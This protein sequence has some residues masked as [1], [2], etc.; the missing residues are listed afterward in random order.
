MINEKQIHFQQLRE[1]ISE[2]TND[3]VVWCG[4]GLSVEVG[5]PGWSELK[6]NILE[7]SEYELEIDES[8]L[9]KLDSIKKQPDFWISFSMLKD[10]LGTSKYQALIKKY[11]DVHIKAPRIYEKIWTLNPKGVITVNIDRFAG[12]SFSNV[13]PGKRVNEFEGFSIKDNYRLLRTPDNFIVNIHGNIDK[14]NT[15]VFTKEELSALQ[16]TDG[17][18]EFLTTIFSSN[19]VLFIGISADDVAVGGL[20]NNLVNE[21]HIDLGN[22]YWI[23]DRNDNEIKKWADLSH[24]NIIKHSAGKYE[25]VVEY[26]DNILEFI[27]KDMDAMPVIMD[28]IYPT[29]IIDH[30]ELISKPANQIRYLLNSHAN[31][32]LGCNNNKPD[33]EKYFHFLD[34]FDQEI[35]NAWYVGLKKPHNEIF[36]YQLI[37]NIGSGGFGTV[38]E[39]EKDGEKYAIKILHQDIRYQE[40]K[41][42]SFRRGVRS[43]KILAG[44]DMEGIVKLFEATEIPSMIVMELIDGIN[45][46]NFVEMHYCTSWDIIL[47]I[48]YNLVKIISATHGVPERV[49]HR[50]LKPTN[51]FLERYFDNNSVN[52]TITDFDF[53]W[54]KDA[55]EGDIPRNPTGYISP[56]QVSVSNKESTR[57]S[58]VDSYSIGMIFY[59]MVSG[60]EPLFKSHL[61]K[62]WEEKIITSCKSIKCATWRSIPIRYSR[63]IELLTKNKQKERLNVNQAMFELERLMEYCH[64][65]SGKYSELLAEELIYRIVGSEDYSID[66]YTFCHKFVSGITMNIDFSETINEIS[67]NFSYTP[68]G[69][70]SHKNIK[71]YIPDKYKKI[72][73]KLV[74]TLW[75]VT[76][77]TASNKGLVLNASINS[78]VLF[79]HLED[80]CN[81]I[82]SFK[83]EFD[84]I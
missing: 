9:K 36:N 22:H 14:P 17:Y 51:I 25:E 11:L 49:L 63:M 66:R 84:F 33:Y 55:L 27:S 3:I 46:R 60:E 26:I 4:A 1:K 53:S 82:K 83:N 30:N 35:H 76:V 64:R 69:Q 70:E 62:D 79:N 67:L 73:A 77:L 32:I 57:S 19:T 20:I 10:L 72:E 43:L 15:W 39:A 48:S 81:V 37:K 38:Y 18:T 28:S 68:I 5:L 65:P 50:D 47:E 29:S 7:D 23:T 44:G 74:S 24:V 61:M 13:Y 71:K 78:T 42:K 52:L 16:K 59:Y 58:L 6:K 75:K 34:E 40:A 31:A 8:T 41:L 21:K 2:K 80:I 56:E 45:L 12:T 54:H